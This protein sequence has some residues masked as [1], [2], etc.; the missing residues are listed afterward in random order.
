MQGYGPRNLLQASLI[1]FPKKVNDGDIQ[2]Q[3]ER[4]IFTNSLRDT[5]MED[6]TN[7]SLTPVFDFTS[8]V[9][10]GVT[11]LTLNKVVGVSVVDGVTRGRV[12]LASFQTCGNSTGNASDIQCNSLKSTT[13][14]N[15]ASGSITNGLS[16]G[17]LTTLG[18]V[19]CGT[20]TA[21]SGAIS[22]GTVS[23]TGS[24]LGA[25]FSAIFTP[26]GA[27]TP[28][29]GGITGGLFT[30]TSLTSSGS[31]Q[32]TSISSL[33]PSVGGAPPQPGNVTGGSFTCTSL[34]V[35]GTDLMALLA[36][37]P[38]PMGPI[39]NTG[40]IG[41]TGAIGPTGNSGATGA[42]G[43]T[44]LTGN[45]GATGPTG[46]S[47]ILSFSPL[48]TQSLL[49]NGVDT[50]ATSSTPLVSNGYFRATRLDINH[51]M[52]YMNY[53]SDGTVTW[54]RQLYAKADS[55]GKV[56]TTSYPCPGPYLVQTKN[57]IDVNGTVPWASLSGVPDLSGGSAQSAT[58]GS[59]SG[60]AAG[61]IAGFFGGLL[62][63]SFASTSANGNLMTQAITSAGTSF[64]SQLGSAASVLSAFNP[65]QQSGTAPPNPW[66][67]NAA[68]DN[69]LGPVN[70]DLVATLPSPSLNGNP[71]IGNNYNA[72]PNA[73]FPT[74]SENT[75]DQVDL[76]SRASSFGGSSFQSQADAGVGQAGFNVGT[77]YG[78][79]TGSG[80]GGFG[81]STPSVG[82][83][84][85]GPGAL[86]N[87][88]HQMLQFG[89]GAIGA[90][91]RLAL[92]SMPNTIP[93]SGVADAAYRL[94][95]TVTGIAST[96]S[97]V[98][99]VFPTMGL[100]VSFGASI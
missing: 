3:G 45:I 55:T 95:P 98:A 49:V 19:S 89:K 69:F 39:G 28:V 17:Y 37:Y 38:G 53:N 29:S 11:T 78:S 48:V 100:P 8:S 26:V 86:S 51:Q 25:S 58:S 40:A 68:W 71:P 62:G 50:P 76:G 16:C 36:K 54:L 1:Q 41:L 74:F 84:T 63:S 66:V 92:S 72:N 14:V 13:Y 52:G 27:T 73:A 23:V 90:F 42:T 60:A 21:G 33:L 61:G 91:K 10:G 87:A 82:T 7:P 79:T 70:S 9:I 4:S 64:T 32:G 99:G 47:P 67:N 15:G 22:G 97:G 96:G 81:N 88:T 5:Y 56:Y 12:P 77:R 83:N 6:M 34:S 30:C 2:Y 24:V 80:T 18:T 85:I 59:G 43:P 57:I 93:A 31:V 65:L 44:G 20:M 94:A 75:W 35:Q 46:P